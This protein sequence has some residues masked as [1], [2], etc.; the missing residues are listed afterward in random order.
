M[1]ISG[2]VADT[3]A[4][5]YREHTHARTHLHT[6]TH[7]H[8]YTHIH[9]RTHTRT[10]TYTHTHT[11]PAAVRPHAHATTPPSYAHIH[12]HTY[13]NP[14]HPLHK[15]LTTSPTGWRKCIGCLKLQVSF[16]KRATNYRALLRKMTSKDKASYAS[17]PPYMHYT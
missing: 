3:W 15:I 2:S 16:R 13:E 8:T 14:I 1:N 7:T 4:L 10:H 17:S 6:H 12:T 11:Q 5:L 9:T